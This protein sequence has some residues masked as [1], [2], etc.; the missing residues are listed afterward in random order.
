MHSRIP[1]NL[2]K[3][4]KTWTKA[5]N[6]NNT[7]NIALFIILLLSS[8]AHIM[9]SLTFRVMLLNVHK[10]FKKIIH[11]QYVTT[12]SLHHTAQSKRSIRTHP[13]HIPI[14]KSAL[15]YEQDGKISKYQKSNDVIIWRIISFSLSHSRI[16]VFIIY[17]HS[18]EDDMVPPTTTFKHITL[19]HTRS[20]HSTNHTSTHVSLA[21]KIVAYGQAIRRY[22]KIVDD[23]VVGYAAPPTTTTT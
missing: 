12:T 15:R 20:S 7:Q 19:T 1:F 8:L 4:R 3:E 13:M 2:T 14:R 16:Y 17:M 22:K 10:E 18:H 9:C 23:V 6:Y 11:T 5:T 21:Y